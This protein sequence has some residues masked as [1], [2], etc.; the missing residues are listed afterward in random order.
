MRGEKRVAYSKQFRGYNIDEVNEDIESLTTEL[1]EKEHEI[2]DLH[3]Q[4]EAL[5]EE[6]NK[7][8]SQNTLKQRKMRI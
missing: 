5:K 6:N 4:I 3:K 8:I 7:L 1:E 2:D